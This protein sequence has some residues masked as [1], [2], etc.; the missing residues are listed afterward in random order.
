MGKT[1]DALPFFKA[2]LEANP[3]IAQF[4][5]SYSGALMTLG[6]LAE[7]KIVFDHAK[8]KGAHGEVFDQL[9]QQLKKLDKQELRVSDSTSMVIPPINNG[10]QK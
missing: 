8:E 7:A 6:R 1:P 2:A 3:N 5:Q 10:G 9:D 4:W